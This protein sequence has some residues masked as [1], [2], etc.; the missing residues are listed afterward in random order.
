[1]KIRIWGARGSH[2]KPHT[3]QQIRSKISAVVQ[4]IQARDVASAE[5]REAFLARLPE[6]LFGGYAGNTAC[7]SIQLES[8]P[9][10][11]FDAGTG[12]T[13]YWSALQ[14][15]GTPLP[16][17]Y[18]IFFSHYHY[19]HIQGFPF[20]VPAYIPGNRLHLYSP[21][22]NL[23]QTL[24]DQMQHPMFPVTIQDKMLA[25]ISFHQLKPRGSVAVAQHRIDWVPLNHPGGS[26]GYLIEHNGIRVLYATD[27]DIG[28][29]Y[30]QR[31][32]ENRRF[33]ENLDAII[34]DTQYTLDEALQKHDWGHTSYVHG[35]DFALHW[36]IKHL[37]MFHHEPS[38][39]DQQL[40]INQKAAR[41]Y[42]RSIGGGELKINL[43]REGEAI[44]V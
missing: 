41:D 9:Q 6:W 43:A 1:M 13:E 34:L 30:Y 24:R 29:D 16:S 35:V 19:D 33:F 32:E 28:A 3:P 39:D 11:V 4:R 44:E 42:A 5:A 20:F 22:A 27:V 2:P 14:Q 7:I 26:F 38:Y 17:E 8:G 18:H 21:Q 10:I 40:Y 25:D 31:S 12:I 37:Y 15:A 23:E 36:G